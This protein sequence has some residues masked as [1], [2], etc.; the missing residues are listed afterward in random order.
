[1]KKRILWAS[2]L[3][4][5]ALLAAWFL[6][7]RRAPSQD[8]EFAVLSASPQEAV[9]EE[10]VPTRTV[11]LFFPGQ[12]G[13][14]YPETREVPDA[15]SLEERLTAVAAAVIK[16]PMSANLRAPLPANVSVSEVYA[17]G[18]GIFALSLQTENQESLGGSGSR[19]ELLTLYSL[20][21]SL[22][23]NF[24]QA[25]ALL[26]ILNG[27]QPSTLAGHIDTSRPLAANQSLVARVR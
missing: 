17:V 4:L 3:L 5:L 1:M 25:E 10:D 13:R 9:K 27:H 20:V 8:D 19:R 2:A 12:G 14:L 16:G 22:L 21:N 6:W 11:K 23:L 26:L 15:G 24:D 18:E 7:P